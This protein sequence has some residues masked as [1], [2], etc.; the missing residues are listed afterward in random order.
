[1]VM[2]F[3]QEVEFETLKTQNKLLVLEA[4]AKDREVEHKQKVERIILLLEMV[5]NEKAKNLNLQDMQ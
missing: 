3:E 1:M 2:T 4:Q 5:K